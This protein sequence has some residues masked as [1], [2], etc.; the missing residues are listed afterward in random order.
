YL[1]DGLDDTWR[2]KVERH[3]ERCP[4]CQK[5]LDHLTEATDLVPGQWSSVDSSAAPGR[6]AFFRKL[7]Q[8]P[9]GSPMAP[10]GPGT[11]VD[12]TPPAGDAKGACPE[13]PA[14]ARPIRPPA[15]PGYE[16]LGELGSGGMGVV[17]R[18]AQLSLD[19]RVVALKMIRAGV[20]ASAAEV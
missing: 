2:R 18:A 5:K 15:I 16:I 1:A 11:P 4:T 6:S 19:G 3:V 10:P 20:L 17:Y 13:A 8:S 12:S 14:D 7:R 9:P